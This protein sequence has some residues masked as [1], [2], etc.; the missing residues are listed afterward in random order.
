MDVVRHPADH[1]RVAALGFEEAAEIGEQ[2]RAKGRSDEGF[3]VLGAE[4]EVVVEAGERLGHDG[5][6]GVKVQ[7]PLWGSNRCGDRARSRGS[8]RYA[9]S[10]PGY[11][12]GAAPRLKRLHFSSFLISIPRNAT[13]SLWPQKPK[14]PL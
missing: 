5:A 8:A 6:H 4:N 3:A 2:P 1:D 7:S 12:S 11:V 14:C 9:R 13:G 10:T